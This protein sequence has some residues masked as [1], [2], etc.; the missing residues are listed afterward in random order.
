MLLQ[1]PQQYPVSFKRVMGIF[2]VKDAL[3][4]FG[5]TFVPLT[6]GLI[7]SSPIIG[8]EFIE[9]FM[10]GATL[11][12]TFMMSMAS[13][14]FMSAVYTS[15][16]KTGGILLL[17]VALLIG[18]VWPLE[19]IPLGELLPPLGYWYTG[20]SISLTLSIVYIVSV[21]VLGVLSVKE[22]YESNVHVYENRLLK[23]EDRFTW[24]GDLSTLLSKEWLELK[25]SG[26]LC[27]CSGWFPR[28]N[29]GDLWFDLY[30]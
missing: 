6:V 28:F 7:I 3:F 4:F 27:P 14:F 24:I 23:E 5:Y 17:T 8:V 13:S 10:G 9:M 16:K 21:S 29:H 11:F 12:M 15:N 25:R 20:N 19:L 26:G 22:K 2:F 18:L 30:L 1:L